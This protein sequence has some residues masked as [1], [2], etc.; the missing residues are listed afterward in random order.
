M[1]RRGGIFFASTPLQLAFCLFG[2]LGSVHGRGISKVS[3]KNTRLDL[4][5]AQAR[6]CA[7]QAFEMPRLQ[8]VVHTGDGAA[9]PFSFFSTSGSVFS[10][11]G[12]ALSRDFGHNTS[13]DA[14]QW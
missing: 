12:L 3:F 11:R 14:G 5:L 8:N 9:L 7:T 2:C 4:P 1:L 6:P 10:T 13:I